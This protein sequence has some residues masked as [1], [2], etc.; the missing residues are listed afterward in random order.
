M[1][2]Y[3][4]GLQTQPNLPY[5]PARTCNKVNHPTPIPSRYLVPYAA[6]I[7]SLC[8]HSYAL[9]ISRRP[10][11]RSG[12]RSSRW[13]MPSLKSWNEPN[14]GAVLGWKLDPVLV[15]LKSLPSPCSRKIQTLP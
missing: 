13:A 14:L 9:Y 15:R 12:A 7:C 11:S 1:R 6:A 10:S 8:G 2:Q 5:T 4:G 3:R